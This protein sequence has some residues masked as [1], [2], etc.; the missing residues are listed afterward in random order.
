MRG[1]IFI[2][3][4]DQQLRE[5]LVALLVAEGFVVHS[6][7]DGASALQLFAQA[8]PDL[9]VVDLLMPGMHGQT[10]VQ[11]VRGIETRHIP[12]IIMTALR[13]WAQQ[14]ASGADAFLEKPFDLDTL[15]GAIALALYRHAP[16]D[17]GA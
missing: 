17:P 4:D 8:T 6:A 2:V 9:I 11:K 14:K 13:G 10:F 7:G 15:L 1:T 3:D 16:T 12:I 5:T